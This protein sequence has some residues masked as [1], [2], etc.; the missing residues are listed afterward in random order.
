VGCRFH[1]SSWQ[2]QRKQQQVSQLSA[3][4]SSSSPPLSPYHNVIHFEPG[5]V[6]R[7]Q[8]GAPAL[9]QI[10]RQLGRL[11][12]MHLLDLGRHEDAGHAQH[13]QLPL[14]VARVVPVHNRVLRGG[15]AATQQ[16]LRVLEGEVGRLALQREVRGHVHDPVPREA[17]LLEGRRLQTQR[18]RQLTHRVGRERGHRRRG[19]ER[20]LRGRE[21]AVDVERELVV[22][23]LLLAH[24]Q[25]RHE[26]GI[27]GRRVCVGSTW[28]GL[29]AQLPLLLALVTFL[30]C[31]SPVTSHTLRKQKESQKHGLS[32]SDH[33]G[34]GFGTTML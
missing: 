18:E 4:S 2:A 1:C 23:H 33:F 30:L 21:A 25:H 22:G 5:E 10:G 6:V 12:R 7:R 9:G 14:Q 27:H 16:H 11:G 29:P 20:R 17:E 32:T 13:A 24:A 15:G 8:L 34:L 26:V 28:W 19:L 3:R 31:A